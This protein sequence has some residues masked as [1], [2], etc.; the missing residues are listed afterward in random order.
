MRKHPFYIDKITNSIEDAATGKNLDT[1][2]IPVIITDLKMVLKK[3]GWRFNWR[4]EFKYKDRQL[5]KLVVR[6]ETMIQGLISLQPVENYIEM[7]LIETAPHNYGS[8]KKYVGVPG[9]L[10]A[11]ACKMSFDFG[12]EGFVGFRAKTQLIKHYIDTL[13]AELIFRDR[14]SISENSAKKLVNSYYK[15]YLDGR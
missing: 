14:M 2:V 11:F 10:V 3:H 6:G 13:G 7:H 15:N 9:N 5:Y 4:S 12:F 1:D 8:S